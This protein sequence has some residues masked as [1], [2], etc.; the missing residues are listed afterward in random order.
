M[1]TH[2]VGIGQVV[3]TKNAGDRVDMLGLGSCVGIFFHAPGFIAAAHCLLDQAKGRS[4]DTPGKFVDTA[5]PHLIQLSGRAGFAA[6]KLTASIAG[7]A[8]IF[9]FSG[10]RPELEIGVR[11]IEA[12]TSLLRQHRIRIATNDTGGVTPRRAMMV[13]GDDR[14]TVTHQAARSAA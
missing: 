6:A 10:G 4:S 9:A 1:S 7:G 8:Q 5:I 11:N 2:H 3:T 14:L 12:A 13:V